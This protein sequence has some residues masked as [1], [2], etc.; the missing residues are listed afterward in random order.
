[1]NEPVKPDLDLFSR[2]L[3]QDA[4]AAMSFF[5]KRKRE[6]FAEAVAHGDDSV[7]L[8]RTHSD[9]I[10]GA[11]RALFAEAKKRHSP[12]GRFAVLALG[13]YGRREMG[14]YCDID[15]L[16]LHDEEARSNLQ[17]ITD[18]ILYPFWDSAVEV[19]GAT[20]TPADCREIIAKEIRA[21]TALTEAR[22]VCGDRALFDEVADVVR[23]RLG[24]PKLKRHFIDTKHREMQERLSRFGDSIYLL[25]PNV[26]EGEGGLRDLHTLIWIARAAYGCEGEEALVRALPALE[27]RRIVEESGRFLWRVRHALHIIDGKRADRLSDSVQPAVA[28]M[29]G[30]EDRDNSSAA[31]GLMSAYYRHAIG[32][33]V[34]CERAIERIRREAAPPGRAARLFR[35]RRIGRDFVRTEHRTLS[36]RDGRFP[37]DAPGQL[38]VFAEA[39]RRGLALDPETKEL[40][41]TR[42][43]PVDD[44]ARRS[45]RAGELWRMMLSSFSGLDTTLAEMMEC[46]L[47]SAWFPEMEPMLHRVQHDGYHSYTAGV[48]S[49]RAVG[50]LS[51]ISGRAARRLFPT[52]A[53][54]MRLVER[55]AV[56]AAATLFHDVGKGSGRDHAA[57][58]AELAHDIAVRL[59]FS[60]RDAGDIAF[61]VRSH[62]L[63]SMLAFR[64]DVR[65]PGLVERFAQSIRSTEM[66]AA[67]YLLTVADLRAVGPH[68]WSEWKG[69]LL[70]ELYGRTAAHFASLK[71]CGGPRSA[72]ARQKEESRHIASV[73]RSLGRDVSVDAVKKFLATLPERYLFSTSPETIAAHFVMARDVAAHPVATAQRPV[74]DRGCTELSVVTPD[75]PGLFARIAGVLSAN[76]ANIIDAQ[77]YTS[78]DGVAIDVFW[79]TDAAGGPLSDHEQWARIREEMAA[80]IIAGGGIEAIVGHRFKRRLLSWGHRHRPPEVLVDND[81]SATDTIVEVS[82]DDR[83]GLLYTIASTFHDLGCSIERARITTHVDRVTDV[84]YIRDEGG[85][86]IIEKERLEKI[87]REIFNSLEE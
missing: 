36:L 45:P 83:R 52:A 51:A 56:L 57:A 27:S 71:E 74:P 80:A 54:A 24:D 40:L 68:I 79:M 4:P 64:R 81:V 73:R 59:G 6:W 12:A 75:S 63:M 62:L 87:R 77:L 28:K 78:A 84:F 47:L 85:A 34:Q 72:A 21:F 44:F 18:G 17:E 38:A 16:F 49:I 43:A 19:G 69:G 29:L 15:L 7:E 60:E 2:E 66:L 65:D 10:D 50:E 13:G 46:G 55:P 86:K 14:L 5:L 23:R 82:A 70:A 39:K 48:H 35:R 3:G 61:L 26:K 30:F 58:G 20:R 37:V 22:L 11:V 31:E 25:Q 9:M 32:L 8:C 53:K 67:L 1:M 33:H 76:G 42:S 41:I